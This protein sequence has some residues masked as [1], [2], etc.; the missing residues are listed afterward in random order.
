MSEFYVKRI[1]LPSGKTVEVVYFHEAPAAEPVKAAPEVNL[2][3]C[4]SCSSELVYP[5]AWM[6]IEN[7]RWRIDL[8]CPECEHTRTD[9]FAH[10]DVER[11]DVV[12]NR[13]TDQVIDRLEKLTHDNMA[14]DIGL[15][16]RAIHA[17]ALLPCDF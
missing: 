12:L 16:I 8:R 4:P 3:L 14:N 15:L 17:D 10:A 6:E 5:T 7:E 9:E 1:L 11:F 13:G 2:E